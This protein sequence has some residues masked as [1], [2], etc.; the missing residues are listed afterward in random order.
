MILSS[1]RGALQSRMRFGQGLRTLKMVATKL[2]R[3]LPLRLNRGTRRGHLR[4]SYPPR[5]L[6]G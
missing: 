6:Q 3:Q 1:F 4:Q 2:L 5:C